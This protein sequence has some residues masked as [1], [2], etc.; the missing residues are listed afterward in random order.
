MKYSFRKIIHHY[1]DIREITEYRS[2]R[3]ELHG[4]TPVLD[5]VLQDGSVA[6]AALTYAAAC[7]GSPSDEIALLDGI[8]DGHRALL[9]SQDDAKPTS[10]P[11]DFDED[12]AGKGAVLDSFKASNWTTIRWISNGEYHLG[13]GQETFKNG[14]QQSGSDI[15]VYTNVVGAAGA[16]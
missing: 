1:N 10:A 7:H 9:D 14:P 13:A 12:S 8:S 11:A 3:H 4:E 6:A 15:Y 5:E 2:E 16:P